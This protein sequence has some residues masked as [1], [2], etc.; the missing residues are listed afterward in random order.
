[1]ARKL[2]LPGPEATAALLP[3]SL[4]EAL[5]ALERDEAAATWWS[6]EAMA[7]YLAFKRAEIEA[8]GEADPAE[9]CTRY[10]AVY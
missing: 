7:A 4:E 1:L 8:L 10:A 2:K 5:A 9:I 3:R 6:K